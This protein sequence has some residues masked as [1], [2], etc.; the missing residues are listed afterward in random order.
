MLI[1]ASFVFGF[2][3]LVSAYAVAAIRSRGMPLFS[4]ICATFT[5]LNADSSQLD[6]IGLC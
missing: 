3:G 2:L 5:A 4:K 1:P 6:G